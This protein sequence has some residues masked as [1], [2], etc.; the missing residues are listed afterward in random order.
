VNRLKRW[1]YFNTECA[2]I[3]EMKILMLGWE[4]PPHNSGGLGVA[5][6]YLSKALASAGVDIDF[7]VPYHAKHDISHMRVIPAVKIDPL[8]KWGGAYMSATIT[9][10]KHEPRRK[11]L[12]S[13]RD[14]QKEYCRFIR[15]HLAKNK[16]DAVHAHD[17]LTFEAGMVAKQEFGLPFI[18]HVH[19]TEFDRSG[20][21][22]N[23]LVHEIER[24]A[25][26]CA[27]EIMAVSQLTKDILVRKYGIPADKIHV[28]YN[29][30]DATAYLDGYKYASDEYKYIEEMKRRGYLVVGTVG[31]FTVQKGMINM[32]RAAARALSINPKLLFVL[33][34][35]GEQ[36]DELLALTASLGISKN[37]I[38]TGFVRGK[39]HR[40]VYSLIDVF[41]MSSVS[42]PFGLTALE[43]AHHGD[44]LVLTK[45]SGV[46]E[47]IRNA[48]KYDFWDE[49][50]LA[51]DLV[52]ISK[53]PALLATLREA[54]GREYLK[55]SW[56][57]VAKKCIDVYNRV[58]KHKGK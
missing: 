29:G 49:D 24:E 40:D 10:K 25:L 45:Q 28:S 51:D 38:F 22:G 56:K 43:A 54:A 3:E 37:V 19:A 48:L 11:Q 18:A 50:R 15:G 39:E 31:R 23:E 12:M 30:F 2:I 34:G 27:D 6:Y 46:G 16:P 32:V 35:D 55:I 14:V 47:V 8:M 36:R 44:A 1:V 13:M 26:L 9:E 58:S 52:G 17:W 7:V 53:S 4:L 41:V 33:A 20:G 21:R 57:D 42:E 5:C